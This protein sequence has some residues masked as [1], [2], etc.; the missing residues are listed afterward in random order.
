MTIQGLQ[1]NYY[2]VHTPNFVFIESEAVRLE[3]IFTSGAKILK[4]IFY[5]INGKFK[6]DVSQYAINFLPNFKDLRFDLGLIG[7]AVDVDYQA[8]VSIN[9]KLTFSNETIDELTI[10]KIFVHGV[11]QPGEKNYLE[12]GVH[13]ISK[14]VRVW[15]GYPFTINRLSGN[16]YKRI[17]GKVKYLGDANEFATTENLPAGP[18]YEIIQYSIK[19][20]YLK[21]LDSNNNYSY[22][23]FNSR[24]NL[25]GQITQGNDVINNINDYT[26]ENE[27]TSPSGVEISEKIKIFGQIPKQHESLIKTL[28]HSLEIYIYNLGYGEIAENETAWSRVKLTSGYDFKSNTK[29]ARIEIELTKQPILTMKL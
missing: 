2:F 20:I 12:E 4:G 16:S 9:F 14:D 1:H 27:I 22:W 18:S 3:V 28:F 7:G 13:S 19:G 8:E 10:S 5:P 6:V 24:N 29:N 21:W 26:S 15:S 25:S 23:L 17:S 11:S